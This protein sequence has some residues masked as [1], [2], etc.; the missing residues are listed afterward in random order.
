MWLIKCEG[1][2]QGLILCNQR[3]SQYNF[4]ES[5]LKKDLTFIFFEDFIKSAW[6]IILHPN[7]TQNCRKN[8]Q[9]YDFPLRIIL[10]AVIHFFLT[11][12]LCQE[13]VFLYFC[14]GRRHMNQEISSG[15]S[16]LERIFK[17]LKNLWFLA[18]LYM[19]NFCRLVWLI[20]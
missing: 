18:L 8:P 5:A 12:D 13:W 4:R 2:L 7:I 1:I 16:S 20:F 17:K 3:M 11:E 9:M 15:K 6:R 19:N 10:K 14:V